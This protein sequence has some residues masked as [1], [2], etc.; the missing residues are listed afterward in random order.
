MTG[1]SAP[2]LADDRGDVT[3]FRSLDEMASYIEVFDATDGQYYDSAGNRI[4][5]SIHD[6]QVEFSADPEGINRSE[7]LESALRRYFANL[8]ARL[9]EYTVSAATASSLEVLVELR[10]RLADTGIRGFRWVTRG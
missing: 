3:I 5:A 2:F 9:N 4:C 6:Y 1:L 10:A 8:P 7:A